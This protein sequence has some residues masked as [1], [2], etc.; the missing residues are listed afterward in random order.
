MMK[1]PLLEYVLCYILNNVMMKQ[2]RFFLAWTN[3]PSALFNPDPSTHNKIVMVKGNKS[4]F[5][6]GHLA[7][8]WCNCALWY[9][10]PIYSPDNL[11]NWC[12]GIYPVWSEFGSQHLEIWLISTLKSC[13]SGCQLVAELFISAETNMICMIQWVWSLIKDIDGIKVQMWSLSSCEMKSCYCL[14]GNHLCR[15]Q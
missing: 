5:F 15:T 12:L 2:K 8:S 6:S 4:R 13:C 7:R 14:N 11:V 10:S 1:L 3:Y 9:P